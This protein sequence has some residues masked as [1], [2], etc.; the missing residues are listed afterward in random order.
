MK[1]RNSFVSNSSSSSFI[2]ATSVLSPEEVS[3][4][5]AYPKYA[6]E[7]EKDSWNIYELSK[8][9]VIVG[10]TIMDND[11]LSEYLG[12]ELNSKFSFEG[13]Y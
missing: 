7:N 2:V 11:D 6:E 12:E 9:G 4:I 1:I 10:F 13:G 5:L 3:K 8:K